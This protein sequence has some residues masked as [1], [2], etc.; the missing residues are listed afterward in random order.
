MSGAVPEEANR[1]DRRPTQ[2]LKSISS[3]PLR[4]SHRSILRHP[5]QSQVYETYS[6]CDSSRAIDCTKGFSISTPVTNV[7]FLRNRIVWR[8][9]TIETMSTSSISNGRIITLEQGWDQEI[10]KKVRSQSKWNHYRVSHCALLFECDDILVEPFV[11]CQVFDP[12]RVISSVFSALNWIVEYFFL[13]FLIFFVAS[14]EAQ[15]CEKIIIEFA[16]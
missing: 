7:T 3:Q 9:G 11:R 14:H 12:C 13:I 2:L 4:T 8:K 16:F 1:S 10:K 6:D 5:F 15:F